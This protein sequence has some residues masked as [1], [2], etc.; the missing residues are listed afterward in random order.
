S[1]F[2]RYGAQLEWAPVKVP[3]SRAAEAR[4]LLVLRDQAVQVMRA[5]SEGQGQE[6]AQAARTTL[7]SGWQ[8]YVDAYGPINRSEDTWK[9]PRAQEQAQKVWELQVEWRATLPEDGEMDRSEVPVPTELA[10]EWAAEAAE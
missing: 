1:G 7:R 5:Q 4:A 6:A 3:A 8:Q 2:V 9:T 10:S